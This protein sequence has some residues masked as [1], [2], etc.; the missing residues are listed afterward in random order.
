MAESKEEKKPEGQEPPKPWLFKQLK[1]IYT[2]IVEKKKAN[3]ISPLFGELFDNYTLERYTYS[4]KESKD[5]ESY[6]IQN[7]IKEVK[8]FSLPHRYSRVP[9]IRDIFQAYVRDFSNIL[10]HD[11]GK[12]HLLISNFWYSWWA[13]RSSKPEQSKCIDYLAFGVLSFLSP[14][15][16][17]QLL[18]DTFISNI[19]LFHLSTLG[20]E[21]YFYEPVHLKLI[22]RI[23]EKF[24]GKE[25]SLADLADIGRNFRARAEALYVKDE[26]KKETQEELNKQIEDA[27]SSFMQNAKGEIDKKEKGFDDKVK[28]VEARFIQIIGIFAAIIAFIVTIVPTAVRLGGASVP[29]ALAGLAIVTVGIILVLAMVFGREEK[30]DIR[31]ALRKG[32][33]WTLGAFGLWLVVTVGLVFLKLDALRPPPDP[34]RVDTVLQYDTLLRIDSVF[35]VDTTK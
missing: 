14:Q 10:A 31:Q 22:G 4:D 16:V 27:R 13:S 26:L 9:S 29:I 30:K 7:G 28:N 20:K 2:A 24:E 6:L 5:F 12:D 8:V 1:K 11:N 25:G 17:H 21:L 34:N 18:H 33:Y 15:V 19:P 32:F 3:E 35:V 23:L